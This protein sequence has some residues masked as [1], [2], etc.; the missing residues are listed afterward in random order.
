MPSGPIVI[1]WAWSDEL[2]PEPEMPTWATSLRYWVEWLS[3]GLRSTTSTA[4]LAES[5]TKS[6]SPEGLMAASVGMGAFGS[7]PFG[8]EM[9]ATTGLVGVPMSSVCSTVTDGVT[10]FTT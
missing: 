2:I 9:V 3:A 7:E 6:V 5:R 1:A 10:E 4:P 8:S